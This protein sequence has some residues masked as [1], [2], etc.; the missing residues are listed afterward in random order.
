MTRTLL[1]AAILTAGLA[2]SG[3]ARAQPEAP[4][5]QDYTDLF[6]TGVTGTLTVKAVQGTRDGRP[7]GVNTIEVHLFHREQLVH[8]F[9]ASL[10]ETG[11][12]V[13]EN[14]PVGI[15]LTPVVRVSYA[16]VVYQEIGPLMD[17]DHRDATF[18]VTVYETTDVRPDWNV[19]MRHI[20]ATPS[21]DGVSVEEMVVVEN[22]GD[23]TWLG[24]APGADGKRVAVSLTL[25]PGARN[26]KLDRGFHGW[27]CT[28]FADRTL[29]VQ[30]PLMPGK[31]SFRFSYDVPAESSRADLGV[32][33]PVVTHRMVAFVADTGVKAEPVGL[34]SMGASAMG[35]LSV[36]SFQGQEVSAGQAAGVVLTGLPSAV[37]PV[38]GSS[39]IAKV[40]AGVGIGIAVLIGGAVV[41]LRSKRRTAL[42]G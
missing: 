39:S 32:V 21:P 14:L 40:V 6:G 28:A 37:N 38:E 12:A 16:G 30:M 15:G 5:S 17:K 41:L 2:S 33:S 20:M 25:P 29:G 26:V 3:P 24:G 11:S 4:A 22:P 18:S 1:S 19:S 34:T 27:C 8:K 10:D 23:R 7:V 9:E 13:L 42:V 35:G 31:A 36:L